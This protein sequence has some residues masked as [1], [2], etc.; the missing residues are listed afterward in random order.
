MNH[1]ESPKVANT[2]AN[3]QRSSYEMSVGSEDGS[4][5][6][7][8]KKNVSILKTDFSFCLILPL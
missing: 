6:D 3:I 4:Q 5:E 8:E 7:K 1:A 2:S